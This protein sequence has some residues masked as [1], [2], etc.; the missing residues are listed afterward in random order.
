MTEHVT[1]KASTSE[2][3]CLKSWHIISRL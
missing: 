1:L 2:A 3:N